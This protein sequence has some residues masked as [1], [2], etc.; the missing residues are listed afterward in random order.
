MSTFFWI[1]S[2][3]LSTVLLWLAAIAWIAVVVAWVRRSRLAA[4]DPQREEVPEGPR[5]RP[6]VKV[7]IVISILGTLR[8]YDCPHATTVWLGPYGLSHSSSGG[9]CHNDPHNGGQHLLG[10][11]YIAY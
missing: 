5:W 2:S 10:N 8:F 9:P 11:W 6:L 7:M 4:D 1:F 3:L